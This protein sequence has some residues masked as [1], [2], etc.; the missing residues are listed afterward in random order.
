M[1]GT[2]LQQLQTKLAANATLTAAGVSI[3][4][5]YR[6]M[7]LDNRVVLFRP[8]EEGIQVT[9]EWAAIGNSRHQADYTIPGMI[10]CYEVKGDGEASLVA[11]LD[12][13]DVIINEILAE[14]KDKTAPL[15]LNN[16]SW[17]W[18][19][20]RLQYGAS[21]ADGGGWYVTCQYDLEFQTRVAN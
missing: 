5:V 4:L 6:G 9:G 18:L 3:D 7:E 11:A 19:L 8:S 21:P 2:F 10:T 1:L 20:T 17:G 12:R 15:S 14:L 16:E 13:V